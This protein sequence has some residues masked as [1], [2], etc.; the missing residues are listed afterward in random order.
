MVPYFLVL[1]TCDNYFDIHVGMNIRMPQAN[2][3]A[4]P[5]SSSVSSQSNIPDDNGSD[6]PQSNQMPGFPNSANYGPPPGMP[7]WAPHGMGPGGVPSARQ[8]S[9]QEEEK[10]SV[11]N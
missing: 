4:V 11:S 6:P 8:G 10:R 2:Q 9:L 5:E 7:V 3:T 1:L